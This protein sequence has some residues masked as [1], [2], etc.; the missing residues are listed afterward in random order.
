MAEEK[1]DDK[2]G[3]P[4]KTFFKESLV[5]QRNE[6]MEKHSNPSKKIDGGGR[7]IFVKQPFRKCDT[8]Q[9]TSQF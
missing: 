4:F 7:G 9:G 6:M 8:L 3:D 2:A 1:R 5:R